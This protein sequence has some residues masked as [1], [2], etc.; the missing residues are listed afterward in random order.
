[1][2]HPVD[3]LSLEDVVLI[4]LAVVV[5]VDLDVVDLDVVGVGEEEDFHHPVDLVHRIMIT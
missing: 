5:M 2:D 1:M 4:T 3:L